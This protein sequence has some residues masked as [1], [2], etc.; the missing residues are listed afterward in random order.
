MR[1]ST[2][3][4]ILLL[5]SD[6]IA[7]YELTTFVFKSTFPT[8]S[9]R[10]AVCRY[11]LWDQVRVD[12]GREFYLLLFIQEH[13]RK[14]YG[15]RHILPY[16]QSRSVEVGQGFISCRLGKRCMPRSGIMNHATLCYFQN[17]VIERIWPEVNH[18]VNY[19]LK[20]KVIEM[21]EDGQINL[22]HPHTKFCVSHILVNVSGY[23]LKFF[24]EAWNLH[25]I[26]GKCEITM[27]TAACNFASN[28]PQAKGFQLS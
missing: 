18:R 21:E 19:T 24:V 28:I 1:G 23:G 26:T 16:V 12:H 4:L 13:L 20:R 14:Q 9:Y 2:V 25:H 17:S 6:G 27:V 11:G 8:L 7:G 15:A 3:L 5:L 22:D 10:K